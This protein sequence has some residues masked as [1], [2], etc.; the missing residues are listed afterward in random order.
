MIEKTPI[1]WRTE[2]Q[3]MPL[4]ICSSAPPAASIAEGIPHAVST[5][6]M[7]RRTSPLL[8]SMVLPCSWVQ[9]ERSSS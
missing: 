4:A 2:L 8:S 9:I 1:G 6:S 7:P 5:L 3:S